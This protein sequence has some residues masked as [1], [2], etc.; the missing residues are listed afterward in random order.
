MATGPFMKRGRGRRTKFY[1]SAICRALD[2]AAAAAG[3]RLST[4]RI[5]EAVERNHPELRFLK[6]ENKL[7]QTMRYN[8]KL[9]SSVSL[10][11]GTPAATGAPG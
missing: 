3:H 6:S 11:A 10:L 9:T 8:L 7:A 5:Y 1:E 2:E 4:N